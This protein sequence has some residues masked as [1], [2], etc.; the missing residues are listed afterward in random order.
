MSSVNPHALYQP[1]AL[2][3]LT[4]QNRMVMAPL[5]RSRANEKFEPTDLMVTYYE[6]RASAGLII[7]EA[8]QVC[9]QG[10]GYICTPGIYSE[11]QVAGWKKVVDAVHAKGGKICLQLWHV[12]RISH[13][14]FQPK[15]EAPVAPSAIRA[16]AKVYIPTGFDD[17]SMPRALT[18]EE[19]KALVATY[20][21]AARNAKRAGFD[22]IEVHG[23]NGYLLD[24][25]LRDKTNQ[26]TD[27]YGGS[28]ENRARF[29]LEVIDAVC[30]VYPASRVGSRISPASD[31]NDIEDSNPQPLFAYVAKSL[32]ERGLGYLHVI[33]GQT[34]GSR[35][36]GPK[37][38]F[39][40]LEHAFQSAGGMATIANNGYTKELAE[41]AVANGTADLVAFG[42]PFLANPDLVSRFQNG[43][44]LNE[45]DSTTFYGG[46]AKGYTDYPFYKA[47]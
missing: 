35:D 5:T 28:I 27:A 39:Q 23:A 8:T 15:N 19:I 34:A 42:V 46:D 37:I 32:G 29:L 30:Q 33:E 36:A 41:A 3:D 12:G 2:G 10:Q 1:F 31:F 17:V 11:G 45:P 26:R 18:L 14:Y 25:F 16:N 47:G 38:D 4:L 20:Q 9:Q 44:P 7:A 43:Y 21:E 40:A 24:Q 22:M 6:Q 13:T